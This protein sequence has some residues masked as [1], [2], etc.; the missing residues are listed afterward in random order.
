MASK[1]FIFMHVKLA[2]NEEIASLRSVRSKLRMKPEKQLRLLLQ[3][4]FPVHYNV[5]IEQT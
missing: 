1:S 4:E 2:S 3:M 5:G